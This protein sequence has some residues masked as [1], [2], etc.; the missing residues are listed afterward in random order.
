MS[1]DTCD[2]TPAANS[3]SVFP[4]GTSTG[5]RLLYM[6]TS[7]P[8]KLCQTF[9]SIYGFARAPPNSVSSSRRAPMRPNH[10]SAGRK[11]SVV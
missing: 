10:V 11:S 5:T 4:N 6:V 3:R 9:A 1:S 2:V 7:V 8:P